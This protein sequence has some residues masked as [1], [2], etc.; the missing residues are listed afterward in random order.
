MDSNGLSVAQIAQLSKRVKLLVLF[1]FMGYGIVAEKDE[2]TSNFLYDT[3]GDKKVTDY[4]LLAEIDITC[5]GKNEADEN[6]PAY[7][8][9]SQYEILSQI[10]TRYLNDIIGY[11]LPQD[12]GKLIEAQKSKGCINFK[13]PIYSGVLPEEATLVPVTLNGKKI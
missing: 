8:M 12:F 7:E 13:M 1:D 2:I 3:H 10:P 9:F 11:S 5:K 6:G 4:E